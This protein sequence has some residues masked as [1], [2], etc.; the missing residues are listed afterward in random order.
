[1]EDNEPQ[2]SEDSA[3]EA[4]SS[5]PEGPS[6]TE[7]QWAMGC[8]LAALVGVVLPFPSLHLIAPLVLWLL[9]R[10]DGAFI[11]DQGKEA[12]NFQISILI[13]LLGCVLLSFIAIG[14]FLIAPVILFA[15]VCVVIGAIK[16]SEGVRFRYPGCI[17]L[18]K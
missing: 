10:E 15:V 18:I 5:A 13:Y 3:F 14:F 16:A 11:D 1:M 9:K 4:A 6:R 8:H 2:K 17:R 12:L 7:R